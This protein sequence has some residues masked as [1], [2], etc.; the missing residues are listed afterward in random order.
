MWATF[1][2]ALSV[3]VHPGGVRAAADCAA[4]LV[5]LN[6]DFTSSSA[7]P[8]NPAASRGSY[9]T[10]TRASG[11]MVTFPGTTTTA[12]QLLPSTP[13]TTLVTLLTPSANRAVGWFRVRGFFFLGAGY[14]GSDTPVTVSAA[15][16]GGADIVGTA[17]T[18]LQLPRRNEWQHVDVWVPSNLAG[19]TA[20]KV[21]ISPG[22]F[23]EGLLQMTD[24]SICY[25]AFAN[26]LTGPKKNLDFYDFGA[27]LTG[28]KREE[29]LTS[30]IRC[31]DSECPTG[32]GTS[33][34]IGAFDNE[35]TTSY[36][37]S[38]YGRTS[39]AI[40]LDLGAPIEVCAAQLRFDSSCCYPTSWKLLAGVGVGSAPATWS[41][42]A[43]TGEGVEAGPGTRSVGLPCATVRHIRLEMAV[44]GNSILLKIL[45]I[46][47]LTPVP[48]TCSVNGCRNGG[49]CELDGTC[50]CPL[51]LGCTHA[52]CGYGGADCAMA[53]CLQSINCNSQLRPPRGRCGGPNTC[54]CQ[55]G[56][57]G[58]TGTNQCTE[59]VCGDGATTAVS[60]EECDDGNTNSG[61][62]CSSTC[63][64]EPLPN[65]ERVLGTSAV[66]R[67]LP[68]MDIQGDTSAGVTR[69]QV[70]ATLGVEVEQIK[71]V[72]VIGSGPEAEVTY[73]FADFIFTCSLPPDECQHSGTCV[74]EN[75]QKVCKCTMSY[76][77]AKCEVSK[78]SKACDHGGV[79]IGPETCAG[80]APGWSGTFCGTLDDALGG[81]VVAAGLGVAA[82]QAASIVL[83]CI[84]W[85]WIPIKARGAPDLIFSFLG[86]IIWLLASL[87]QLKGEM[88][89]YDIGNSTLWQL[90]LPL[91]C[92]FAVWLSSSL[93]YLRAMVQIHIFYAV[94]LHFFFLLLI[95]I[96]PWCL[97]CFFESTLLVLLISVLCFF[98]SCTLT[99]Q[100]WVIRD[101]LQDVISHGFGCMAGVLNILHSVW[102]VNSG[103]IGRGS[104][105]PDAD[106]RLEWRPTLYSC[107]ATVLIVGLKY[108]ISH[109]KLLFLAVF[110]A[111]DRE[112]LKDYH[113]E[114]APLRGALAAESR[115][116]FDG[117]VKNARQSQKS[118][119]LSLMNRTKVGKGL[120]SMSIKAKRK[121]RFPAAAAGDDIEQQ[122]NGGA[123]GGRGRSVTVPS[124][125][126]GIASA[127]FKRAKSKASGTK[128]GNKISAVSFN[129]RAYGARR[130]I[131]PKGA[132]AQAAAAAAAQ[133]EQEAASAKK[134]WTG[135]E[136]RASLVEFKA[137]LANARSQPLP[138][139][140]GGGG[141][142]GKGVRFAP[143]SS[144]P[145]PQYQNKYAEA[146][147][148][149]ARSKVYP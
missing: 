137:N 48:T 110:K 102:I 147:A 142:G 116:N 18:V 133:A 24:I 65:V 112:V 38:T 45:E 49:I 100:L 30:L 57:H 135:R 125:Y 78:C 62:G 74:M 93:V 19:V 107:A 7:S 131:K 89:G 101:E 143:T 98:Y 52:G 136:R 50:T 11:A 63:K 3:V 117:M 55:A 56:F 141:G 129:R 99:M 79:C 144:V 138:P 51:T 33:R 31:P 66:T 1:L 12:L 140:G 70:A 53:A 119:E 17:P 72:T 114:Y 47:L 60:G 96:A 25:E 13:S 26:R 80:C 103:E 35:I 23:T 10:V 15:D 97:A 121:V 6:R 148:G 27:G 105:D 91:T 16:A 146:A 134:Q 122:R 118:G 14:D 132:A 88:F 34:R 86:G 124:K 95:G 61:D 5:P 22:V 81:V 69:E 113:N 4:E 68:K 32:Y 20:V 43:E 59:T 8:V 115:R 39:A 109:G 77:G 9:G 108:F 75:F 46:F 127:S 71:S 42:W 64:L 126:L 21:V 58:T 44:G 149:R 85:N 128:V 87:A 54:R 41:I 94:P 104:V 139:L 145:Q 36:D 90:Y 67:V 37:L 130:I 2:A 123:A 83:V 84:K 76:S 120:K 111:N 92:G 73:E 40:E 106:T 29:E 28:P 82:V